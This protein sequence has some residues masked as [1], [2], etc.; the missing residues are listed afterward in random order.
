MNAK[1]FAF[2]NASAEIN[3]EAAAAE[4]LRRKFRRSISQLI[5]SGYLLLL[6]TSSFTFSL[7]KSEKQIRIELRSRHH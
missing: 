6:R 4:V 1:S 5:V 7:A 3:A 2:A